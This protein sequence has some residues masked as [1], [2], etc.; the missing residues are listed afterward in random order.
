MLAYGASC[1]VHTVAMKCLIAMPH[2][3]WFQPTGYRVQSGIT[4]RDCQLA[5]PT[6]TVGIHAL[7]PVPATRCQVSCLL[8]V[9]IRTVRSHQNEGIFDEPLGSL[10]GDPSHRGDRACI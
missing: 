4:T 10:R 3:V 2:Q 1:G 7:G 6:Q 5:R 8:T 9:A